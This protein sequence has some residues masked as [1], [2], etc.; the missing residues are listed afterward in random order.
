MQF[1]TLMEFAPHVIIELGA[2]ELFTTIVPAIET[3][4]E[5]EV[6]AGQAR[7]FYLLGPYHYGAGTG[8]LAQKVKPFRMPGA[9]HQPMD[10][11]NY[12][13]APPEYKYIYDRYFQRYK[14]LWPDETNPNGIDNYYDA[15]WYVI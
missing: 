10:G 14:N 9:L 5:A 12:A 13:S 4:W 3:R 2:D 15:P 1:D 7:P 11:V 6:P 8:F